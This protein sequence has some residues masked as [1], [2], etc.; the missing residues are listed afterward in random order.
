MEFK[1]KMI[2]QVWGYKRDQMYEEQVLGP[3]GVK[4]EVG[5]FKNG[6]VIIIIM[7]TNT[8]RSD[9][10]HWCLICTET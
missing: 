9:A 5:W 4:G 2:T 6:I 8:L 10:W 1:M 3:Q 7:W